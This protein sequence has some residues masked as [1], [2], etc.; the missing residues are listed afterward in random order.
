[1]QQE[2]QQFNA[3]DMRQAI[4]QVR[5]AFGR[6][7]LILE[8]N[9][10]PDGAHI[11]AAA[12][13]A[14]ATKKPGRSAAAGIASQHEHNDPAPQ[15]LADIRSELKAMQSILQDQISDL[16]WDQYR[17][18]QPLQA[19]LAARLQKHGFDAALARRMAATVT[20]EQDPERAWHNVLVELS[21]TLPISSQDLVK[22]GGAAIFLGPPGAG[23]TTTVV[24][25]AAQFALQ[26]GPEDVAIIAADSFRIGGQLELQR[27]G[28]LLKV[29]VETVADAQELTQALHKH[30][31]TRLLLIDCGGVSH[32]RPRMEHLRAL[33]E[34]SADIPRYL[35]CSA[36]SQRS[37]IGQAI[38]RLNGR[39][40]TAAIITK[41]DETDRL[42][43]A[44]GML[45]E[46][47]LPL[48]YVCDGPDVPHGIKRAQATSLIIQCAGC[49]D[50][51]SPSAPSQLMVQAAHG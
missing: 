41:L 5:D 17:R 4:K 11:V 34:V 39:P 15:G 7:A 36:S 3:P 43:E 10:G 22:N 35:V 29:P 51:T 42:G 31:N 33:L 21:R 47:R 46:Q 12:P 24:K 19:N 26:H 2:T 32:S 18:R 1:M 28:Q 45:I 30:R 20:R 25:I 27:F 40:L 14:P 48:A 37:V 16:A 6:D 13:P 50:D 9:Q 38:E 23:K 44:L 49:L 8:S